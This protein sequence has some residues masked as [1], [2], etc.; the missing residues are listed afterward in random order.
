MKNAQRL[1]AKALEKL[2]DKPTI[3]CVFLGLFKAEWK[4][5]EVYQLMERHPRFEPLVLV[6]PIVNYGRDNMLENL[7]ASYAYFQEKVAAS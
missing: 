3:R 5:N 1:Q 6:C 4:Y 7:N 2:K